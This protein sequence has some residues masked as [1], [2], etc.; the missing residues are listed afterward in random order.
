[1][2]GKLL[3]DY[4]SK[5]NDHLYKKDQIVDVTELEGFEDSYAIYHY[6]GLDWVPKKI[7]QII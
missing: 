1:M 2:K 3:Q 5:I 6:G 4:D 7:I